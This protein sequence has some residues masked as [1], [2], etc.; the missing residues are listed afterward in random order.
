VVLVMGKN[1]RG[2]RGGKPQLKEEFE[3][4]RDFEKEI[5]LTCKTVQ[6]REIK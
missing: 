1:S 3:D 6:T 4:A 2:R 5:W